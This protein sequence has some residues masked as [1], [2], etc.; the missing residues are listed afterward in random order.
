[1][2][3]SVV[4]IGLNTFC[5]Y[6]ADGILFY[7][8]SLQKASLAYPLNARGRILKG[9]FNAELVPPGALSEKKRR[10]TILG[11]SYG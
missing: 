1:M 6:N 10:S 8:N 9:V 7:I 11:I 2:W 5:V 4:F 3:N